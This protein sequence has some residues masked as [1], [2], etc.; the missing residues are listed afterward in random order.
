MDYT[1]LFET[2]YE[3]I[4]TYANLET[5]ESFNDAYNKFIKWQSE[6]ERIIHNM[7]KERE[8]ISCKLFIQ[9]VNHLKHTNNNIV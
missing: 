6:K 2:L 5:I 4:N 7:K 9:S 1:K 8:V 3:Y